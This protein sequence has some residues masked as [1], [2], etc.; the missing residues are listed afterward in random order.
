VIAELMYATGIRSSEAASLRIEDVDFERALI[1]IREG[2]GG[3]R[4]VAYINRYALELISLYVERMRPAILS[5]RWARGELLFGCDWAG[6]GKL[7]NRTLRLATAE[8]SMTRF[9]SHDFRHCLG[10]HLL[11][12]GCNIRHIQQILGHKRLRNTEV[13]TKVDREELREVLDAFHP[14][15][16][17]V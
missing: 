4:R 17:K 14:R 15:K 6:F 1:T 10:Y 16:L 12:A 9:T 11:R 5:K 7:V 3:G 2:K 8:L 13:Y